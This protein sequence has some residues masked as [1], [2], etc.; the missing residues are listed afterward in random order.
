[1]FIL[2]KTLKILEFNIEKIKQLSLNLFYFD[3]GGKCFW[4][5]VFKVLN[6]FFQINYNKLSFY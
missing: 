2:T 5:F 4:L 6:D 1:M 3:D